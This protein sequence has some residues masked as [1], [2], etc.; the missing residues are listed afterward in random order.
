[1]NQDFY[2][3]IN[4]ILLVLTA[5]FL[6]KSKLSLAPLIRAFFLSGFVVAA[7]AVWQFGN[8]VAGVPYPNELFYS[9]PGWAILTGQSIGVVPRING[10]FAEPSAMAS[11]MSSIVCAA[12]W[13]MLQGNR[14]TMVRLL[15][16]VGLMTMGLSTSTTGFGVLAI[17]A[18]GVPI[19]AMV[20]ASTR[21]MAAVM[22][23]G[24]PLVLL[25]GLI[26]FGAS[27]LAP[28]INKNIEEVFAATVNKQQSSSYEDRTSADID[29]LQATVDS[30]GLGA[31]WGSNRSSSLV[32]GLLAGIGVP[33]VLGLLWFGLGLAG[34]VR[35]ARRLGC[36]REQLLVIDGCCGGLAGFI[37]SGVLSGPTISSVAFYFLLALLIACVTTVELQARARS[38]WRAGRH[39]GVPSTGASPPGAFPP[40]ASPPGVSMPGGPRGARPRPTPVR[41]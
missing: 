11:Y 12:G 5:L 34:Q 22:K 29:S 37:L 6:T 9:N 21:M 17:V 3:A 32:P 16:I 31:G 36:S 33:G 19:Y 30:Y 26:G 25:I 41:G 20:T 23:V 7:V 15:F 10:S 27:T 8:K 14:D 39:G 1:L 28:S 24:V 18:V 2:L 13:L 4:C 40:G 38:G 35:R